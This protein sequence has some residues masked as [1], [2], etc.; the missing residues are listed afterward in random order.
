MS[1]IWSDTNRFSQSGYSG[2]TIF[3]RKENYTNLFIFEED[4]CK[5]EEREQNHIEWLEE[6]RYEAELEWRI[7][8]DNIKA[9]RE[10]NSY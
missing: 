9:E 2:K 8:Q 6:E 3:P 7:E 1:T 5:A 4:L 10:E